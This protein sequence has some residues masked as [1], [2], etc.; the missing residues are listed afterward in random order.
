MH[1]HRKCLRTCTGHERGIRN[2]YFNG[3]GTRFIS[4]GYDKWIKVKISKK[5]NY[6]FENNNFFVFW[7]RKGITKSILT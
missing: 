1:G 7:G 4:T 3:D 6:I 2:I 5:T